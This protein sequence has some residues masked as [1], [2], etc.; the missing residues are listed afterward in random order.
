MRCR[1]SAPWNYAASGAAPSTAPKSGKS[2]PPSKRWGPGKISASLR[3]RGLDRLTERRTA[4]YHPQMV[5]PIWA[6]AAAVVIRAT[7]PLHY[8]EITDAV[9]RSGLTDLART[10]KTPEQ[11]VGV[12]L[13]E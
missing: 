5:V 13:R 9:L 12:V 10:G 3:E 11:T 7:K 1:A 4:R 2:R 8:N 6:V